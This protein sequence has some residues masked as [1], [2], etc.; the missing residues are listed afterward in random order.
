MK[1][2]FFKLAFMGVLTAFLAACASQPETKV[3]EALPQPKPSY[4]EKVPT[5]TVAQVKGVTCPIDNKWEALPWKAILPLTN[6]C[7]KSKD[8]VKVEK[9]GN[10]M[11]KN[12]SLT[13]WGPY[14]LSL[15][16][17]MRHDF[18]RAVWMLE[19][20]LK[21]DPTEGLFHYELGRVHWQLKNDRDA[22]EH[23]KMA[24]ELN[25]SLTDA[26]WVM[27]EMAAQKQ[28]YSTAEAMFKKA[29]ANDPKHL[30][31]LLAMASVKLNQKDWAES[32]SYLNQ[33]L[34]VNPNGAKVRLSLARVQEEHLKKLQEALNNY[35][36]LRHLR[37]EKKL[38]E[39]VDVNLDEKIQILEKSLAQAPAKDSR[40]PSAE[41]VSQ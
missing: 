31:S 38:A 41:R 21:K 16:A 24:S 3:V 1:M 22:L 35:K 15:A 39:S 34:A 29:L 4:N 10:F 8:W 12:F 27:G 37:N 28:D 32:E 14:Y 20:A 40:A 9:M 2:N 5:Q 13:P 17:E 30:P 6:A 33:A 25:P 7:V 11:A 23:L 18:P 36:Q 26:H 19:L